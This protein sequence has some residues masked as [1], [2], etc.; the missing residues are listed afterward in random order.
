ME[1]SCNSGLPAKCTIILRD[2][3]F[4]EVSSFLENYKQKK[5]KVYILVDPNTRRYCLPILLSNVPCLQYAEIIETGEGEESKTIR[6]AEKIWQKMISGG[7]GRHTLIINLGGGVITDLGGFIASTLKRGVTYINIPTTLMGM[8]DASIGGKTAV[9]AGRIKNQIGTF[10]LP[11]AVFIHTGFLS[12]LPKEHFLSGLGEI[13][14]YALIADEPLW[15]KIRSSSR[16]DLL[17]HNHKKYETFIER[18][19]KIKG[20]VVNEDFREEG[21][22]ALLNFG[23]TV[24]HAFESLSMS[25]G[26]ENLSHGHAIALGMICESFISNEIAGLEKE[27]MNEIQK[28]ILGLFPHVPLLKEDIPAVMNFIMND[29]KK[30]GGEINMTLLEKAG[31]AVYGIP[32]QQTLV[33]NS[34]EY[35]SGLI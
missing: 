27:V 21:K 32:C 33:K 19:V 9:N 8:V 24:G 26:K 31:K 20:T 14:K 12:T 3:V 34:L 30:S 22:R 10:Y 1:I 28:V 25:D 23:H 7:A 11:A 29:K 17:S 2:D 5:E 16:N 15:K 13:I 6:N 4:R 18:S 35:Y